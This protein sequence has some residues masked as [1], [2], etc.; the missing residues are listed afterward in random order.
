MSD[1]LIK[2]IVAYLDYL[3]QDL[4]LSITIHPQDSDAWRA[5]LP[6]LCYNLHTNPYCLFVKTIP[7]VWNQ[8]IANQEKVLRRCQ[9]GAFFGVC[10]FGVGEYVIPFQANGTPVGFISVSGYRPD[11]AI[12]RRRL[13]VLSDLTG[14]SHSDLHTMAESH[15]QRTIPQSNWVETLVFP[16][17]HMLELAAMKIAVPNNRDEIICDARMQYT[18]L[19]QYLCRNHADTLKITDLSRHFHCS[20]SYLS[21]LFKRYSGQS[22][23][24]FLTGVRLE[25][26]AKLLAA[27]EFRIQEIALMVG[28]QNGNYFSSV[29]RSRFHVSPKDYRKTT[30]QKTND[31]PAELL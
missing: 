2:H 6:L 3:K 18:E 28:F 24:Q 4:S 13:A 9:N 29:F 26:A 14:V 30:R 31:I 21:H 17:A 16:L 23:G 27:T 19:Y 1:E 20:A 8:C 25:E 5:A 22:I 11:D 15:L 7:N 12:L 10:P